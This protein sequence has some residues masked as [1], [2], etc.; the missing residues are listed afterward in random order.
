MLLFLLGISNKAAFMVRSAYTTLFGTPEEVE[1]LK[2][3]AAH[4]GRLSNSEVVFIIA[5]FIFALGN[6]HLGTLANALGRV[7]VDKI[8]KN[9]G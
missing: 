6:R 4:Y 9:Q 3:L 1:G 8:H 7:I 5:G 2:V